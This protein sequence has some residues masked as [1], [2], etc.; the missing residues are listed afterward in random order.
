MTGNNDN[1]LYL[2]DIVQYY[3]RHA[4]SAVHVI[5]PVIYK[6]MSH[7]FLPLYTNIASVYLYHSSAVYPKFT[8]PYY[9]RENT[10]LGHAIHTEHTSS[11]K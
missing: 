7:L 1:T 6:L 11:E 5:M 3:I 10:R 2:Q 4:L 9:Y 8:Y